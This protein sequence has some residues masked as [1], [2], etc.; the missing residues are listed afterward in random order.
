M[1]T[2]QPP[3]R[4]SDPA[5]LPGAA[6]FEQAQQRLRLGDL[7]VVPGE[8]AHLAAPAQQVAQVFL[9]FLEAAAQRERDSNVH[10]TGHVDV[11]QNMGQERSSSPRT[12]DAS[13]G[14]DQSAGLSR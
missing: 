3:G 7:Q 13:C 6:S 5:I 2:L 8:E 14:K 10:L 1:Q 11:P 9:D 4:L 12:R